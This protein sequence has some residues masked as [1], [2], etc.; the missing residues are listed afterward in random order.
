[1]AACSTNAPLPSFLYHA[2][3]SSSIE[4]DNTSKSPSPSKSAE[5]TEKAK[6]AVVLMGVWVSK[7]WACVKPLSFRVASAPGHTGAMGSRVRDWR[8]GRG[9]WRRLVV[10]PVPVAQPSAVLTLSTVRVPA[11]GAGRS[12]VAMPMLT[13][14][15]AVCGSP[16]PAV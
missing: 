2:I 11:L 4:A 6:S 16:P 14:A 9:R 1:M 3:L 7:L 13:G 10:L 5:Y 12:K 8:S 15:V